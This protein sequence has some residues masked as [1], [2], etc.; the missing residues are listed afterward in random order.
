MLDLAL[1][2][3]SSPIP[4]KDIAERQGI[5]QSYLDNLMGPL[6]AAGLVRTVRGTSGGYIL[7]KPPAEIKLND[8]WTAME[9]SVCLVYCIHQPDL[10]PRIVES[11]GYEEQG[12]DR[13]SEY[14]E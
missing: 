8:I 12:E 9:G 5:S 2:K 13:L 3:G 14:K 4:G 10:C 6:R 7:A 1:S 11:G